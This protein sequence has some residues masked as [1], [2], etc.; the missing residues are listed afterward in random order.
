MARNLGLGATN[1]LP[2]LISDKLPPEQRVDPTKLVREFSLQDWSNIVRAFS[3]WKF[4]P[5]VSPDRRGPCPRLFVRA[6]LTSTD[7]LGITLRQ[8]NS[9]GRGLFAHV[10]LGHVMCRSRLQV[11]F[12]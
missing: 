7:L 5:D 12:V 4:A 9:G 1:L 6:E 11:R 10:G 2:Q 3:N 8:R